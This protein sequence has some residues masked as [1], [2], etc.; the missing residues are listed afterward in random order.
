MGGFGVGGVETLLTHNGEA[1]VHHLAISRR[2]LHAADVGG[3]RHEVGDFFL[4]EVFV[5]DRGGE[6]VVDR[7]VEESLDLLGV[8]IDGEHAVNPGSN[9]KVGDQ[10]GGDGDAG[11]ILAV[12]PGI[13]KEGE[14]GRDPVGGGA[15]GG[16]HHDQQFH[17]VLVGGGAGGL[18]DEDI[19]SANV[20]LE[21]DEGFAVRKGSDGGL[22]KW[23]LDSGGDPLRQFAVG[24][25]GKDLQLVSGNGRHEVL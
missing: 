17:Q 12:L 20:V 10:F 1:A 25:A 15:A 24:V 6:K 23:D 4:H 22:A 2:H 13:A 3:D 21:F 19:V 11:L 16:I 7:N 18:N 14:H 5:E 9:E 8:Q